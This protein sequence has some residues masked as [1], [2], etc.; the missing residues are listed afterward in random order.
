MEF[1]P[2]PIA[3]HPRGTTQLT[4]AWRGTPAATPF[5]AAGRRPRV[6]LKLAMLASTHQGFSS[7]RALLPCFCI[8]DRAACPL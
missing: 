1:A 5:A 6:A 8:A 7:A 2:A 4:G 3:R